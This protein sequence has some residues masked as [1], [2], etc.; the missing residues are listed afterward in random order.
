MESIAIKHVS[1]S[2]RKNQKR[3]EAKR[4]DKECECLSKNESSSISTIVEGSNIGTSCRNENNSRIP[5]TNPEIDRSLRKLNEQL[6]SIQ[7]LKSQLNGGKQLEKN[8]I[9][10]IGREIDIILKIQKLEAQKSC[11]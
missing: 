8:Q 9:E 10:K 3:K 5:T 4:I 6:V 2:A 1:K 7:T 11:D